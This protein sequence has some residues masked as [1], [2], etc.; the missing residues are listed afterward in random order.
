MN[1]LLVIVIAI[2]VFCSWRGR[3]KGFVKTAFTIFSTIIAI[4]ITMWVSPYVSK[5]MKNSDGLNEYVNR[6]VSE[7][8]TTDEVGDSVSEEVNFIEGLEVPSIIKDALIKNKTPDVYKTMNVNNFKGYVVQFI[9]TFIISVAVFLVLWI[10]VKIILGIISVTLDLV[11]SLP[12]ISDIDRVGGLLAGLVNGFLI[13]W[14]GLLLATVFASS[15]IGQ[16]IFAQIN[17]SKF[18]SIVYNYNLILIF[19]SNIGKVLF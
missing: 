10:I 2:L 7:Q 12:I 19:L 15:Q 3:K 16:S 14:I 1:W 13:V 6:K 4:L 18:L 8:I 17:D 11:S 5:W 9:S